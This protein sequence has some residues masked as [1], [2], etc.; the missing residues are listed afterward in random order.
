MLILATIFA[1]VFN[2]YCL[3]LSKGFF[4]A[5]QYRKIVLAVVQLE[6]SKLCLNE[7]KKKNLKRRSILLK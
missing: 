6:K 4:P 5:L 2:F 7:C 3:R 1:K